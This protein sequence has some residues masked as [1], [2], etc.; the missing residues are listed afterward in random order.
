VRLS[1][2]DTGQGIATEQLDRLFS[3]FD[4]LGAENSQVEGTGLGLAL[5]KR[6]VE[7]MGGKIGVKTEL[8]KGSLFWVELNLS[9]E[10]LQRKEGMPE[11]A[12]LDA[13]VE[14]SSRRTVLYIEDNLSNLKLIEGILTHRPGIQLK[15]AMQG[16]IGISVAC[17][18]RPDLILLDVNLPDMEGSEVLARLR[19]DTRTRDIPVVV[20]SAD[21]MQTQIDRLLGAGAQAYLTKPIDVTKFLSLLDEILKK[22]ADESSDAQLKP[23]LAA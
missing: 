11:S 8:G 21:A 7:A 18:H 14:L 22:P 6:L 9:K 15:S 19:S 17:E 10:T 4:R 23:R 13:A 5:S 2:G 20:V 3:P 16:G 12:E 1:I